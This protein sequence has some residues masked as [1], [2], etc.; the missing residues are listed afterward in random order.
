MFGVKLYFLLILLIPTIIYPQ[1]SLRVSLNS[2]KYPNHKISYEPVAAD[3]IKVVITESE[4]PIVGLEANDF[5][6][7]AGVAAVD[8]FNI[9]SLIQK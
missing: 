2:Q 5:E 3:R 6:I 9:E 1:Q 4:K 7:W 8:T